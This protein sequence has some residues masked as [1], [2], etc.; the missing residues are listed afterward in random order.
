M[1]SQMAGGSHRAAVRGALRALFAKREDPYAGAD[2]ANACRIFGLVIMLTG[3]LELAFLPFDPPTAALGPAGWA[4]AVPLVLTAVVLGRLFLGAKRQTRFSWLLALCYLALAQVAMLQW[5][6]G[7]AGGPYQKLYLLLL[8]G[9]M[10]THP[11]RRA[12]GLLPTTAVAAFLPLA[13][14][15]WDGSAASAT[16]TDLMLW[17]AV[18]MVVMFLMVYVRAQR[19]RMREE[20]ERAQQLARTDP[21]TELPNR[22][23]FEEALDAEL[24]RTRRAGSVLSVVLLDIDGFKRINDL[25]GHIEGDSCLRATAAAITGAVRTSD[26][27]FRWAGDEF[28]VML[29]DTPGPEAERAAERICSAVSENCSSPDGSPLQASC[30]TAESGGDEDAAELIGA[31]DMLL[32]AAKGAGDRQPGLTPA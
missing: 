21:L 14:G 18:G 1:S 24:A 15:G 13:Y 7:G 20:E 2:L 31:A 17:S 6:S 26:R 8:C 27:C 23:A 4:I 30:G 10:G 9:G 28:V 22:R 12:V 5:L 16:A 19:L 29:P 11:P 32:L 25:Y 3:A